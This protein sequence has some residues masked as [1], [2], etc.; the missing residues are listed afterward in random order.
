MEHH[1]K[2]INSDHTRFFQV[3]RQRVDQYF[4]S[5]GI[6]PHANAAMVFK[7]FFMLTLYFLP[8]A[9]IISSTATGW[10]FWM[11]WALMGFGLAGIG[12]SVMHDANHK[13]YSSSELVNNLVGHTINLVGGDA[14][15]WKAQHN[16]LHHTYTNIHS[17]DEDIDNKLIMRFSPAGRYKWIQRYQ[18]LYAFVL[19]S[20]MTLYWALLKDLV[21][22]FRYTKKGLLK[23]KGLARFR[24]LAVLSF[25]K[26][27]YIGY[28]LVLPIVL[29]DVPAW[30]VVV[31]FLMLHLIAGTVLS[32][33]FQLAHV[34][35]STEFPMPNAEGNIE[36]E[37]AIHQLR[38]T[39]DFSPHNPFITFYVGGL[40]YQAIHHLFP[41]I[42]HIHYP[43]LAPIV[44]ET[45]K[46]FG[47]PYKVYPSFG[48]ALRSHVRMLRKLGRKDYFHLI[49]TMG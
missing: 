7:T 9:L 6:S 15:N 8:Y 30:Q 16:I 1:V 19:Y 46:E 48:S 17:L 21:Q 37:W 10:G 34:V 5:N 12:M 23:E 24:V 36:T 20:I 3:L 26:L 22:H 18:F 29:L 4:S 39:A 40:N 41:R 38:T 35:E 27:L 25:W 11:C 32:V 49:E 28:S 2:F 33:V 47:I 14:K 31:G 44:A 43:K 42:C 13:A 45:A